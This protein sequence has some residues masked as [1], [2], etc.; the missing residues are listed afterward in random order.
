MIAHNHGQLLNMEALTEADVLIVR[1]GEPEILLE[2]KHSAT[3]TPSK[4]FYIAQKDLNTSKNYVVYP[5]ERDYPLNANTQ[6]IGF[7]NLEKHLVSD[8]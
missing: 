5:L 4:G 8:K 6:V 3:P 2:I 7:A 1:G